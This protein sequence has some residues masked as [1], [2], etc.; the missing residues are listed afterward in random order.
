MSPASTL[1]IVGGLM[2]PLLLSGLERP[3]P[4][5]PK[6]ERFDPQY[7]WV[8]GTGEA[9]ISSVLAAAQIKQVAASRNIPSFVVRGIVDENIR[10]RDGIDV[11]TLNLA[12]DRYRP[13]KEH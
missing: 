12:L 1:V 8:S 2:A 11:A 4:A 3:T 6:R 13:T 9:L 10:G 5:A 7:F